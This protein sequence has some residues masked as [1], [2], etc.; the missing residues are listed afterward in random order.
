MNQFI[1]IERQIRIKDANVTVAASDSTHFRLHKT[2]NTLV[3]LS[4][5]WNAPVMSFSI[6]RYVSMQKIIWKSAR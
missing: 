1:A 4:V 2:L 6:P 5:I 3:L